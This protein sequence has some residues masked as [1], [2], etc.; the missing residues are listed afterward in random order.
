M[1]LQGRPTVSLKEDEF[2]INCNYSEVQPLLSYF[3]NTKGTVQLNGKNLR[4]QSTQLLENSYQTNAVR[5]DTGTLIVPDSAIT[6]LQKMN[7]ILNIQYKQ[8]VTDETFLASFDKVYPDTDSHNDQKPFQMQIT[9][10]HVY[11][12]AA[13]LKTIISYLALYIGLV[14][15]ITSAAVL[16]LQQLSEASDNMERYALLKKLGTEEKMIHRSL[17]TQIAIYFML[18]LSLAIVH[19]VVGIHVANMVVAQFGHLNILNT[20]LATAALFL[21]VYGGYFL[22]TYFGSKSMLRQK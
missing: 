16:A 9:K 5:S 19:S 11:D 2:L 4:A 13:G 7:S 8:N 21:I 1:Q 22:A 14:F 12:Q 18:P 20:T 15:L 6:G 17:F 10:Q 3:L